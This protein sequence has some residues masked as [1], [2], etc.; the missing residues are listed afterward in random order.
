MY[1]GLQTGWISMMSL[2]SSLLGYAAFKLLP[3]FLISTPLTVAENVLLQTTST[4]V[5]AM[6]LTAGLIG[7]IPA[8]AQLNLESDG[9]AP[10]TFSPT[11]LITWC[12]G[13]A[14]FGVFLAIPLREQVIIKEKLAFPSGTATAQILALLHQKPMLTSFF[15]KSRARQFISRPSSQIPPST[16]ETTDV[17]FHGLNPF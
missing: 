15:Y 7:I 14:F 17:H 11:G 3:S 6:P 1:F 12:F 10:I 2:Q 13:I 9:L 16:V 4:A 5:C 8:L